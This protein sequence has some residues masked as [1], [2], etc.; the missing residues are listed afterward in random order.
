MVLISE[1]EEET[2]DID[3]FCVDVAGEIAHFASGGR[4]FL[5]TSVSSS[6]VSLEILLQYFR[7]SLAQST[8]AIEAASLLSAPTV[9]IHVGN[10]ELLR[11][12]SGCRGTRSVFV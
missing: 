6:R 12:F 3:W 10:G 5:P 2:Q 8:V 11:R 7:E 4:G 9:S 1:L